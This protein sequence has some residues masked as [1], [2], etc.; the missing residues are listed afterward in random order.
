M[1]SRLPLAIAVTAVLGLA[2]GAAVAEVGPPVARAEVT[3]VLAAA[4]SDARDAFERGVT[5]GYTTLDTSF[6]L[7]VSLR[8][9]RTVITAGAGY[10]LVRFDYEG[11]DRVAEPFQVTKLRSVRL[12]LGL[13][14]RIGRDTDL[15]LSLRPGLHSDFVDLGPDHVRFEGDAFVRYRLGPA[16]TMGFGMTLTDELGRPLAL[17]LVAYDLRTEHLRV[18][19]RLPRELDAL[20]VPFE[21]L[22]AGLTA[23]F[24]GGAYGAG[25]TGSPADG[26]ALSSLFA[27]GKLE[28]RVVS[29][30]RVDAR[31]GLALLRR[32]DLEAG[33]LDHRSFGLEPAPW[34]GGGVS[35]EVRE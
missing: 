28:V 5:V 18:T 17:P 13:A 14:Q 23:R 25:D 12:E 26:V 11:Y 35:Y 27:G 19:A 21:R 30:L 16:H 1:L 20:Y 22:G 32:F 34:F 15:V 29:A 2:D 8:A 31:G 3:H 33:D 24:Q 9:G 10:R 7:P 4:P 6:S